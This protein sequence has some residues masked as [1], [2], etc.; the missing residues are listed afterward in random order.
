M[1]EEGPGQ[2]PVLVDAVDAFSGGVGNIGEVV[3]DE[4]ASSRLLSYD[5]SSS[6][7]LELGCV[8]V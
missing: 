5:H 8:G 2:L 3:A 6:T 4:L 7:G 1:G